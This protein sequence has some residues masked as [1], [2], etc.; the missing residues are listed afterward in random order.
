MDSEQFRRSLEPGGAHELLARLVGRWAGDV[1]T[2]FEPG[3][4]GDKAPIRGVIQAVMGG[5]FVLHEYRTSLLGHS[6][7][8]FALFGYHLARERFEMTWM[9]NCHLG[10][11]MMFAT[12]RRT[13]L[14]FYVVGSYEDPAGGPPWRWRTEV[15]LQDEAHLRFVSY[16]ISPQGHEAKAV[17]IRY[18]REE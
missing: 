4:L 7:Q 9:D 17:D 14:G 8:G 2:W 3:K 10:T 12:G 11:G 1:R 13:E 15:E 5:R 16:N 18:V 6:C